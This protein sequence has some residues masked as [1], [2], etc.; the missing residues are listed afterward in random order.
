MFTLIKELSTET[1]V[2]RWWEIGDKY[3]EDGTRRREGMNSI[4]E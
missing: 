2:L 4:F 3:I 1:V